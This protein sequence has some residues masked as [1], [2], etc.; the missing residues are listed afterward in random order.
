MGGRDWAWLGSTALV[1]LTESAWGSTG[2]EW[3][4]A[5]H[6]PATEAQDIRSDFKI[7]QWLPPTQT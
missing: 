6:E 5:V 4:R 3:Q 1:I 7:A 2:N